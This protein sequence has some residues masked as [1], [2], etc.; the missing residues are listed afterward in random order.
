MQ[1]R[2]NKMVLVIIEASII[3][4]NACK[5]EINNLLRNQMYNSVGPILLANF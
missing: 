5:L 3:F 4:S 1:K 2:Y